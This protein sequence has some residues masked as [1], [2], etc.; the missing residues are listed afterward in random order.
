M[1]L[2]LEK[3]TS[4]GQAEAGFTLIELLVVISII[5]ILA[6][7]LLPSMARSQEKAKLAVCINNLRQLGISMQ[8]YIDDHN[9]KF[10]PSRVVDLDKKVKPVIATIGGADP[11]PGLTQH[12]AFARSRP[13][14]NYTKPSDIYRCP[15]DKGQYAPNCIE[16]SLKP[17]N[18]SAIGCSYQYNAGH[19]TTISGGGFKEM[20]EDRGEGLASKSENWVANPSRYILMHEPSARLYGC[21]VAEWYQWHY[22]RGSSDIYDPIYARPEFVSPVLFVDLHVTVHNFSKSLATDPRYPYEQTKDWVW[23]KPRP[24]LPTRSN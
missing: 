2:C 8:V 11:A 10:P 6:S 4:R 24:V 5:A 23:Y 1:K 20:P 17:S 18:F 19:L 3:N 7:L 12:Y 22:V 9:F 15:V 14:Y 16:A 13:L 21:T